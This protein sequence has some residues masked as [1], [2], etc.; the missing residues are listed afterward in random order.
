M[1][2]IFEKRI[3]LVDMD[4]TICKFTKKLLFLAHE[5][6]GAPLL[7]ER[8]LTHFH[9]ENEFDLSLRDQIAK[10][11]DEDG[12]FEDLEPV[13]G[14]IEA[15]KEMD[16]AGYKVFICTSP[17]K[18]Y[19]N[20]HCAGNKHR[21]VMNHLGKEWTERVIL[22]RDKTLVH[23][24]VLIDDKPEIE[25]VAVPSWR[26]VYFDQPYNRSNANRVRLTSWKDWRNVLGGWRCK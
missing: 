12:F 17:K 3:I 15:L 21:W 25:G 16:A 14:A 9:T 22:T 6:L 13:E 26:H 11:S 1:K 24:D 18:F 4:G 5:R 19:H 23:G 2:D 7:D 10:L 8:V 20:P